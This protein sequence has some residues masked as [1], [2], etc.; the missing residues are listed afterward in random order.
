MPE[1]LTHTA[2]LPEGELDL[3]FLQ[4]EGFEG[5]GVTFAPNTFYLGPQ[6]MVEEAAEALLPST[7][8]AALCAKACS[9]D[10]Q[11]QLWAW[12]GAESDG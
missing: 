6:E 11:C 7:P 3:L 8:S 12:C 1:A 2:A 4:E 5:L 9:Q 10:E